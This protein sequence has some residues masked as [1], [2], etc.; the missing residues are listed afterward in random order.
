MKLK[1]NATADLIVAADG[2][3]RCRYCKYLVDSTSKTNLLLFNEP[4]HTY[5]EVP[6]PQMHSSHSFFPQLQLDPSSL[7]SVLRSPT[8]PA[9]FSSQRHH[10]YRPTISHFNLTSQMSLSSQSYKRSP[11]HASLPILPNT[12]SPK[13]VNPI[14]PDPWSAASKGFAYPICTVDRYR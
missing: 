8:S 4:H 10:T 7:P 14:S 1:I 11:H 2:C 5:R 9:D 13:P 6:T 12:T 3:V